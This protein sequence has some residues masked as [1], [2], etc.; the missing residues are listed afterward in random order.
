MEKAPE[1]VVVT[2]RWLFRGRLVGYLGT[3]STGSAVGLRVI[4]DEETPM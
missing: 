2:R 1:H 3:W 4:I